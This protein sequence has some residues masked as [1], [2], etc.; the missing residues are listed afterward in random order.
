MIIIIT[1]VHAF[2]RKDLATIASLFISH[3]IS[4]RP[5]STMAIL[6]VRFQAFIAF[7]KTYTHTRTVAIMVDIA[8]R[9]TTT[10]CGTNDDVKFNSATVQSTYIHSHVQYVYCIS[11]IHHLPHISNLKFNT[12]FHLLFIDCVFFSYSLICFGGVP[13]FD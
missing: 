3:L 6:P 1:K 9:W 2:N 12:L 13:N 7:S 5:I 11:L 10:N 8:S 4:F